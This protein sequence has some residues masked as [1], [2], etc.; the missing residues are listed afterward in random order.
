MLIDML[1]NRF[2]IECNYRTDRT[3]G[4]IYLTTRGTKDFLSMI[5]K[6]IPPSMRYKTIPD[7][8]DREYELRDIVYKK[9]K[10]FLK[11]K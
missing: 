9:K 2:G 3:Y 10:L 7:F 5:T 1:R 6:Y 4:S 8:E 11:Q